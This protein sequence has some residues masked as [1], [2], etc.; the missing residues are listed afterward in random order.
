MKKVSANMLCIP[1]IEARSNSRV[2]KRNHFLQGAV[3]MMLRRHIMASQENA[4]V[5]SAPHGS[6]GS[7]PI[8]HICCVCQEQ[9][10]KHR[11]TRKSCV[12]RRQ[13]V[14]N[15]H[16]ISQTNSFFVKINELFF[17]CL[18]LHVAHKL[19]DLLILIKSIFL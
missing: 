12:V 14:C 17:L 9:M 19:T 1:S 18:F 4:V 16:S 8:V 6:R 2:L 15:K 5:A 3:E 10:R 11:K 13:P 7:T